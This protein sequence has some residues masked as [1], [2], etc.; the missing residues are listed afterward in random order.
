MNPLNFYHLEQEPFSNAPVSRFYYD[1][2]QN[3]M[4]LVRVERVIKEMKGLAVLIGEIGAGKTTLARKLLD[5]LPEEEYE[6]ALLVII[7]SGI[8]ADWLLRRIAQQLGVEDPSPEKLR[9]L[10][11]LYRRLL[12]IHESGRKAVVLID[13]AQ[14]LQTREIMEEF[15]GVL[16]L[17]IPEK[18]L[19]TFVFF[20]LPDIEKNLK[21]DPPLLQRVAVKCRLNPLTEESTRE[22]IHHRIRL[23]GGNKDI[24]DLD[25]IS[26]IYRFSQG[27]PRLI[28][29]IADNALFEGALVQAKTIN[30]DIIERVSKDLGL[31]GAYDPIEISISH[32]L[33]TQI[34]AQV[35]VAKPSAE[36]AKEVTDEHNYLRDLDGD[37]DPEQMIDDI[38]DT[39]IK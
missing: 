5:S 21:L 14:M 18:K 9:L 17:E 35:Q 31:D 26:S 20:G 1:S 11:Q 28:N 39:S 29:T 27:S 15:R 38:E 8:T 2:H 16:N 32:D 7:H 4:A 25:A 12:E 6:A 3:Q 34:E 33:N 24:F 13:E 36:R 22:Y 19:I 10:N 23:A 30:V 37:F